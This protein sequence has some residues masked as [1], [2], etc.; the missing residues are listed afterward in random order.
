MRRVIKNDSTVVYIAMKGAK[1]EG[2]VR[3]LV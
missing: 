1:V 2:F 3:K